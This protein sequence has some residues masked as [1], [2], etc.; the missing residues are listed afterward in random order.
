MAGTIRPDLGRNIAHPPARPRTDA[1]K[2]EAFGRYL[3]AIPYCDFESIP[4]GVMRE[5]EAI[6]IAVRPAFRFFKKGIQKKRFT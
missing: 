1:H 4:V 6:D 2:Q 5:I 3:K